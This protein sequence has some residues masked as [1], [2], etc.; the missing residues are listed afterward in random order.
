VIAGDSP[1]VRSVRGIDT[2][3]I[4]ALEGYPDGSDAAIYMSG[5]AVSPLGNPWSDIDLFAITDRL[6]RGPYV[7]DGGVNRVSV[8]YL[9]DRRI[10]WEFWRPDDV[11]RLAER[12]DR[13]VLGS[14]DHLTR[15]AFSFIEETFIHRLRV[16]VPILNPGRV[17]ALRARFDAAKLAAYQTQEVIRELGAVHDDV[18]GMLEA[19]HFDVAALRARD[20]AGLAADVYIHGRG[21][22]DPNT[23]WR[24]RYLEDLDDGSAFH[25]ETVATY[26]R[27]QFPDF[28][29]GPPDAAGCRRY[30]EASLAFSRRMTAWAQP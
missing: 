4:L 26:W 2:D 12:L 20:L 17:E 8:Q 19:G 5:S 11:G 10:D 21:S 22:T 16:G 7:W 1:V 14:G 29:G 3:R 9:D 25:R 28:R 6:P 23:K 15:T 18:C 30:A 13:L 27:L 24:P